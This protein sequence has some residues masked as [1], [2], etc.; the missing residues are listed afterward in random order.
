[1]TTDNTRKER[2]N[3]RDTAASAEPTG[4]GLGGKVKGGAAGLGGGG[5]S[6]GKRGKGGGPGKGTGGMPGIGSGEDK[7]LTGGELGTGGIGGQ[8]VSG[9][10][11][12]GRPLKPPYGEQPW[13][14]TKSDRV[15]RCGG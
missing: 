11:A 1:M 7:R 6:G 14:A 8:G 15:A 2:A 10:V 5:A 4:P 13:Q 3:Y 9:K 12:D